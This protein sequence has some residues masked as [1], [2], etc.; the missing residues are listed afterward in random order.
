MDRLSRLI[1]KGNFIVAQMSHLMAQ[2]S[3]NV[4]QRISRQVLMNQFIC[5]RP[6]ETKVNLVQVDSS[7]HTENKEDQY[8]LLLGE[9]LV[10]VIS[11]TRNEPL[12]SLSQFAPIYISPNI[13]DGDRM[14]R[15]FFP[16]HEEDEDDSTGKDGGINESDASSNGVKQNQ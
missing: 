12:L 13:E 6:K 8:N 10:M 3:S 15:L 14:R 4:L 2:Y 9:A 16:T 7:H 11:K 5:S 1:A